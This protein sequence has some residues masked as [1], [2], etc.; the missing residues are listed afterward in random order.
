MGCCAWGTL[1]FGSSVIA[2][3]ERLDCDWG[4]HRRTFL[5]CGLTCAAVLGK[6]RGAESHEDSRASCEHVEGHAQGA[7]R[8][9]ACWRWRHAR[10]TRKDALDC[11]G[12]RAWLHEGTCARSHNDAWLHG[13]SE[14]VALLRKVDRSSGHGSPCRGERMKVAVGLPTKEGL[15]HLYGDMLAVMQNS[16]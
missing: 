15:T 8:V 3:L 13:V 1:N 9:C 16:K 10:T 12:G 6:A 14:K 11:T 7:P 5:D 4:P 2:T